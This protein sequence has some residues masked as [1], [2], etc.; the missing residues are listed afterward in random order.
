MTNKL[1]KILSVLFWACG[2]VGLAF[3]HEHEGLPPKN[4]PLQLDYGN[5]LHYL[6]VG[7]VYEREVRPASFKIVNVG[8]EPQTVISVEPTC[9]CTR[10][11][12]KVDNAVILP[13]ESLTV[14]FEVLA[15]EMMTK[16]FAR[17][18]IVRSL[19]SPSFRAQYVGQVKDVAEVLPERNVDLPMQKTPTASWEVLFELKKS[20]ELE[21]V[22]LG[23]PSENPYFAF[24][25]QDLGEGNYT[26]KVTPKADLPY[27]RK[28]SQEIQVPVLEPAA[29]V[30]IPLSITV[31]VAEAVV[32]TPDKWTIARSA[33]EAAGS[34]T[35]RF[36]YGVVPGLQEDERISSKDMM[37]PRRAR[38]KNAVP[39]KFVR[40]HHDWDDLFAHLEFRVPKGVKLEKLRHPTGIE[41]QITVTPE[42]FAETKQ[43][44]VTPFRGA[45][46]CDPITIEVVEE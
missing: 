8:Q 46:D 10:M 28:F 7:D 24:D 33:L 29:A 34:L 20:P 30:C 3:A 18:F 37:H 21:K 11:V 39:L 43:L 27:M 23:P 12:T 19:N 36:A 13:G 40:E 41:L 15:A 35:A 32:F 38:Q 44:V 26:L 4:S 22:V 1:L 6:D 9:D 31:P 25:F 2:W 42:S 16:L 14:E 45:N 5:G 17:Y